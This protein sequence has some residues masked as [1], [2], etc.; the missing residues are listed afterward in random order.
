[1][2]ANP[3]LTCYP[4]TSN[5]ALDERKRGLSI[6][7]NIYYRAMNWTLSWVRQLR[8]KVPQQEIDGLFLNYEETSALKLDIRDI[9][10]RMAQR[11]FDSAMAMPPPLDY[12][13]NALCRYAY[14]ISP[15]DLEWGAPGF[16]IPEIWRVERI[17]FHPNPR[18]LPMS[19]I[20]EAF[21][22]YALP[23]GLDAAEL[24][25]WHDGLRIEEASTLANNV[26]AAGTE[27][28][29]VML[30][31][32]RWR[33][34]VFE[35]ISQ[36][37]GPKKLIDPSPKREEQR[38]ADQ[39]PSD[40]GHDLQGVPPQIQ[41]HLMSRQKLA[42]LLQRTSRTLKNWD[43]KGCAPGGL[44]WYPADETTANRAQ[45]DVAKNWRTIL[46]LCPKSRD[47]EHDRQLARELLEQQGAPLP[48]G[49][50]D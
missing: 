21:R 42:D 2:L 8:A 49:P 40:G 1:M 45:Y 25:F 17:Q 13:S 14:R 9:L 18:F 23:I 7:I 34:R 43:V 6:A 27:T 29:L 10:L 19:N 16:D 4:K 47:L 26:M 50:P 31:L 32:K 22:G 36:A 46:A 5:D 24:L 37:R 15:D 38:Q 44:P 11:S 33:G 41:G 3:I 48:P 39:D 28:P 20:L 12:W 30:E 35:Q